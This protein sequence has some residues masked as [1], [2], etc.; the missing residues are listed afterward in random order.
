MNYDSKLMKLVPAGVVL[1]V[2]VFLGRGQERVNDFD[3]IYTLFGYGAVI[4]LMA[5]AAID[6]R[7]KLRSQ[8]GR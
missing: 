2:A 5:V 8:S 4:A 1:A 6:Y 7:R 3:V